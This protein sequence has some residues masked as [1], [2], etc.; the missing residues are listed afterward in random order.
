[1]LGD[2]G[3]Q[4]DTTFE[5][6]EAVDGYKY[7]ALGIKRTMDHIGRD[8]IAFINVGLPTM[9]VTLRDSR[10]FDTSFVMPE[11]SRHNFVGHFCDRPVFTNGALAHN[12]YQI[13]PKSSYEAQ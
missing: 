10:D 12:Q 2:A 6:H 9:L 3:I 8:N 11:L 13:V 7:T 5:I 1:M 4:K